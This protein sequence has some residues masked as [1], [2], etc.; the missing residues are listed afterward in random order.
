[1]LLGNGK[2][3]CMQTLSDSIRQHVYCLGIGGI[4]VGALAE[5]LYLKGY[6]VSGSDCVPNAMTVHLQGLGIDIF[7]QHDI[8]HLDGVDLVVYT[9]AVAEDHPVLQYAKVKGIPVVKRGQLLADCV[10]GYYNIVVAG[11][12]G[13]TTT[14]AL[15]SYL[16]QQAGLDPNYFIGG[17]IQGELS[18]V[19]VTGSHYMIAEADESDGSFLSLSSD[20]AIITNIDADH[21]ETYQGDFE[22]LKRS[23]LQF[24]HQVAE[25]GV[26][27]L[28]VDNAVVRA[29]LPEVE[30]SIVTYGFSEDAHYRV[31]DYQQHALQST[32][33]LTTN[34]GEQDL[35]FSMPGQ[36]NVLNAV[37]CVAVADHLAVDRVHTTKAL[38]DF[39]GVGRRLQL[40]GEYGE[41]SDS[42]RS[43][44]VFE[45]YGHHP[46]EI[47]VTI[48]TLR[49]AW[50]SRR[51]VMA[52]QPHRFSRTQQLF[53]EFVAVLSQVDVLFLLEVY[54]A[55]ESPLEGVS[56][57][58]LSDSIAAQGEPLP[59]V[60]SDTDQ[61]LD[62]LQC[63]MA[64]GDVIVFQG[65]GNIGQ[66]AKALSVVL[67]C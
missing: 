14:T 54:G 16:S 50:S 12:H 7:H 48:Q 26:V 15:M 38:V 67:C 9:S 34:Q 43:I 5:F 6:R 64:P 19:A 66:M 13:K 42:D 62:Q 39:P 17:T 8:S 35:T 36:H 49:Q 22:L 37:A 4:G 20:I 58:A 47:A 21:L 2:E 44:C 40:H 18:P 30:R 59:V 25:D 55:G 41:Y 23:F 31:S 60:V 51:L 46:A 33:R 24:I 29:L 1:M 10:R 3:Q 61:L 65:A 56:S 53:D 11:T 63:V 27:V 32:F 45:D 52:F 57:A 28:C